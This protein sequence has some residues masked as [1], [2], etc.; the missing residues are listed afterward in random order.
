VRVNAAYGREDARLAARWDVLELLDWTAEDR[1]ERLASSAVKRATLEVLKRN[2]LI[3]LG[4]ALA[5]LA[6]G[7]AERRAGIDRVRAIA[8]DDREPELLRIT[9]RQVL[10]RLG[11]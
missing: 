6:T 9:A 10:Q 4:N 2:A 11:G 3:V 1:A 5:G 7:A 8:A